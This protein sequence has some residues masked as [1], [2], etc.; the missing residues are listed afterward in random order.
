MI[1]QVHPYE[2]IENLPLYFLNIHY[3]HLQEAIHRPVGADHYR[4]FFCIKGNGELIVNHQLSVIRK[5]MGFFLQPREAHGYYPT[6]S[7]W[8]L[9]R[10]AF[11]GGIS[12]AL[13]NQLHLT[14]SGSYYFSDITLFDRYISR[15]MDIEA[16]DQ[17]NKGLTLSETCYR[18]LLDT[19]RCVTKTHFN[20]VS[21]KNM[22]VIKI[23][24]YLEDH[25]AENISLDELAVLVNLSR[26]YMC[27]LFKKA[28]N[29]TIIGYL[30]HLRL[31]HACNL[32]L[33]YPEKTAAQI[34]QLCG[35]SSPS[36]F[37]KIFKKALGVTPNGYRQK[38]HRF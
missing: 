10:I 35:F 37:G 30:T 24:S 2:Y 16:S 23:T 20:P 11:D 36:Y 22:L 14:E 7:D 3:N 25:Y 29:Y 4:W 15:I 27:A 18:F 19:A 17:K 28:T 8:T 31:E 9:H 33:Q 34:G 13:L 21:E 26:D 5:G 6:S 12:K 1:F 32:L 38:S